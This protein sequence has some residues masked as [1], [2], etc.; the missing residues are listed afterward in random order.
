MSFLLDT[1][2]VSESTKLI[3]SDKVLRWLEVQNEQELFISAITLA[4]LWKGVAILGKSKRRQKLEEFFEETVSTFVGR[5]IAVDQQVAIAWGNI[6]NEM[7]KKGKP[8]PIIDGFLVATAI[9]HELTLV[10]RNVSDF[11]RTGVPMVNPWE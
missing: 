9:A 6:L 3:P 4:E 2:V 7:E 11:E 10:T 1:C 8:I 5:V